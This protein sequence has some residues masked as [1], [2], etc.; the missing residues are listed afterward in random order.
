MFTAVAMDST[1]ERLIWR[2]HPF[3]ERYCAAC[4][5]VSVLL[6]MAWLAAELMQSLWWAVIAFLL[7]AASLKSFF[8]PSEF[9]I[10]DDGVTV[11]S[12]FKVSRLRWLE[13][14]RFLHDKHGGFLST[15]S[16]SS[17]FDSF[18]GI[19]LLFGENREAVIDR[20]SRHMNSEDARA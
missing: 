14:R 13:I 19:H 11:R 8:L 3:R 10:D 5:A 15:R 16:K 1:K 2:V 20:I 7:L 6:A 12:L 4:S 17:F 18:R 9:Q